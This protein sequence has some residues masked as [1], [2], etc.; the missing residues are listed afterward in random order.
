MKRLVSLV[1]ALV[2]MAALVPVM[3]GAAAAE[4]SIMDKINDGDLLHGVGG[5]ATPGYLAGR[6]I[7]LEQFVDMLSMLGAKSYFSRLGHVDAKNPIIYEYEDYKKLFKLLNEAGIEII[8]DIYTHLEIDGVLYYSDGLPRRDLSKGS[9]Y[10][11]YL[12]SFYESCR[13]L[14]DAFPEV[15]VWMPSKCVQSIFPMDNGEPFTM[16]EQAEIAV[17]MMYYGN[18]AIHEANPDAICLSA[19]TDWGPDWVEPNFTLMYE[20][21]KSG[22]FGDGST[23]TDD[24]FQALAW[25]TYGTDRLGFDGWARY[26]QEGYEVAVKYGDGHKKLFIPE[27]GFSDYSD[28]VR[29]EN[30]GNYEKLFEY[31][32]QMDFIASINIFTLISWPLATWG[33]FEIERGYGLFHAPSGGLMPKPSAYAIQSIYGGKGDLLKYTFTPS[34]AILPYKWEHI[35]WPVYVRERIWTFAVPYDIG[36]YIGKVVVECDQTIVN[37]DYSFL[38]EREDGLQFDKGDKRITASGNTIT[39]DLRGLDRIRTLGFTIWND[40]VHSGV[41]GVYLDLA[42]DGT[43]TEYL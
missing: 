10:M 36:L 41:H 11:S 38:V 15:M 37:S 33:N 22:K 31:I 40:D 39:L 30:P 1:L 43:E 6:G 12:N 21:I 13:F 8:V 35:G 23:N 4:K 20:N 14:A 16:E 3:M 19:H 32:E 18:K 42:Y 29:D 28:A 5:Y 17:D 24:Y 26:M 34:V 7:T 25:N 9:A 27:M 2:M